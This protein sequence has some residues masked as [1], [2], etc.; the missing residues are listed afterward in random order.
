MIKD[1]PEQF[2]AYTRK[3]ETTL[4]KEFS[5]KR[6]VDCCGRVAALYAA[7]SNQEQ[8]KLMGIMPT[9]SVT[10]CHEFRLVYAVPVFNMEALADW[11]NFACKLQKD[12]VPVDNTHEFSMVSL[13]LV[14]GQAEWSALRK[15]KGKSSEQVYEKPD[16]GWS[17]V[18]VALVD[19]QNNKIYASRMGAP[20]RELLGK[21]VRDSGQTSG[22]PGIL[23]AVQDFLH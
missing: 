3:L 21:T 6:M 9:G 1:F 16:S 17:S 5:V 11:W 14:A 19:L 23:K 8:K 4:P 20:L 15:L 22:L 18:R 7:Y 2:I 13:I 12:I 10:H